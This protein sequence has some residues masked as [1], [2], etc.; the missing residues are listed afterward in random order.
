MN[1]IGVK[2]LLG[3]VAV[4][5]VAVIA[6]VFL[7]HNVNDVDQR[8]DQFVG[9]ILPAV[10]VLQEAGQQVDKAL[11]GSY[12]VYGTI[13]TTEAYKTQIDESMGSL[14]KIL[15]ENRRLSSSGD[16]KTIAALL[17]KMEAQGG[18]LFQV[19]DAESIDWDGA[20]EQ[21]RLLHEEATLLH[22][23]LD[24]LK[25][26][27]EQEVDDSGGMIKEDIKLIINLIA[28]MLLAIVVVAVA[29][30][31]MDGALVQMDALISNGEGTQPQAPCELIKM[32][33]NTE[34]A[35]QD[36]LSTQSVAFSHYNNV[37]AQLP[38]DPATG[39]IKTG[40]IKEQAKQCLKNIKAILLEGSC[41]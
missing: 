4:L 11:T 39:K 21:L 7:L 17:D 5:I 23:G 12:A 35:P 2:A 34:N 9:E 10:T 27:L 25:H 16:Y 20:R 18:E 30:L 29:A 32:A 37:S 40:D 24:T 38:I 13:I 14:H 15:K 3:Y 26:S 36:T 22:E 19:M 6:T 41:T 28:I 31:P 8:T 33:R 1:S